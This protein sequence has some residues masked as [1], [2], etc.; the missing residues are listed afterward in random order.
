LSLLNTEKT[1]LLYNCSIDEKLGFPRPILSMDCGYFEISDIKLLLSGNHAS[2]WIL[3][4]Q[5]A[6]KNISLTKNN[7]DCADQRG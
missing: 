3:A 7:A 5:D 6:E 4:S 2:S 1:K